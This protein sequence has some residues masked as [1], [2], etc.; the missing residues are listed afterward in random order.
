RTSGENLL[1]VLLITDAPSHKLEPPGNPGRFKS[2]GACQI[3]RRSHCPKCRIGCHAVRCGNRLGCLFFRHQGLL[4]HRRIALKPSTVLFGL[5]Y[6]TNPCRPRQIFR[7]SFRVER[8]HLA[9]LRSKDDGIPR[10]AIIEIVHRR[11]QR[12]RLGIRCGEQAASPP[13]RFLKADALRSRHLFLDGS[14]GPTVLRTGH[15]SI[16]LVVIL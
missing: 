10:E 1:V 3:D 2:E 14:S 4:I 12:R 6:F 9:T 7:R 15:H 8:P 16:L 13:E 11:E 5:G